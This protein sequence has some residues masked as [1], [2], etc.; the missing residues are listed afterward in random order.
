MPARRYQ[1][2]YTIAKIIEVLSWIILVGGFIVGL[3]LIPS[4]GPVGV[5]IA[6]AAIPVGFLLVFTS[7]LTLITI[8]NE[9]NTHTAMN[10]LLKTNAMLSETLGLIVNNTNRIQG[11]KD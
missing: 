5:I 3:V 10:E 4:L 1:T 6:I 11:S 9:N 8:D 2:A 7:Q